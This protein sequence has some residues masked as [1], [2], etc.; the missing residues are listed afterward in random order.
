MNIEK[1]VSENSG[2]G[3]IGKSFQN[4]KTKNSSTVSKSSIIP[5]FDN[6]LGLSINSSTFPD[7]SDESDNESDSYKGGDTMRKNGNGHHKGAKRKE[8]M[9]YK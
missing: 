2:V 6:C 8:K 3:S 4:T 7:A 5:S 9:S 1:Q